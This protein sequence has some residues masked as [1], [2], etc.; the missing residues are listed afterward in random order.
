M[1][2][3]GTPL[4]DADRI[5]WLRLIRT[6]SVGPRLFMDLIER[7]GSP[8]AAIDALPDIAR[9][10]KGKKR[11]A[12]PPVAQI[13]TELDRLYRAGGRLIA[14]CEPDYPDRLAAIADPPPVLFIRGGT[15][16]L[17]QPAVAIV[18]ARNASS[19][20]KRFAEDI[21]AELGAAGYVVVSGLARGIDG[22]AHRG[23]LPTGTIAAVAGGIDV[24]YPPEHEDL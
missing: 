12:A 1:E 21:A 13:E 22:A 5:D 11:L 18:G 2:V 4:T 3:T 23:A 16:I 8:S 24:V 14:L 10:A 20:G 15:D 6:P 9:R 17:H 19:N 7:F